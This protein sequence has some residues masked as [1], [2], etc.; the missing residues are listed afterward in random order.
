MGLLDGKRIVVTGVLNDASIA[1][2]VASDLPNPPKSWADLLTGS[3][4]VAAGDVGKASQSNAAVLACA[5]FSDNPF[6]F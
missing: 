4:K 1:F 2:A 5:C 3:Y 6:L